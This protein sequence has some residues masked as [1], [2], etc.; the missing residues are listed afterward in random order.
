MAKPASC[1]CA[2]SLFPSLI[3]VSYD[4]EILRKIRQETEWSLDKSQCRDQ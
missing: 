3:I 2:R 4:E 1:G